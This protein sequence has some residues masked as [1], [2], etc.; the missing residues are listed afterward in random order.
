[1][2]A[3]LLTVIGVLTWVLAGIPT[4]LSHIEAHSLLGARAAI[5]ITAYV[6]WV[7]AFWFATAVQCERRTRIALLLAQSVLAIVCLALDRL[8]FLPVLLVMLAGELGTLPMPIGFSWIGIHTLIFAYLASRETSHPLQI[9][10]AYL[11]FQLFAFF[12]L[13]IAHAE[14]EARRELAEAH[15]ELK[16]ANG[17]LDLRTRSEERLRIA[18]DLHDLLGHHLTALSLNLE[19]AT[20]LTEGAARE[21]VEKSRAITKL[22]LSDVRDVV[23]RLRHDEPLDLTAA[24]EA[25]RNVVS[26]PAITIEA[27]AQLVVT[28]SAVAEVTLRTI[29]EIVTNSVRHASARHLRLQLTREGSTLTIT[30]HDDGVGTDDVRFGNGLRGMRERAEKIGGTV[31]V[32]SLRGHGFD[33]RIRLPLEVT[34]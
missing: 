34:H 27:P 16:V 12:A 13:R 29:Q 2:N 20:H 21:Q 25:L 18:R 28:D 9:A 31:E 26:S 33:V 14:A 17:L 5:W 11:A 10:L 4:V 15:A 3:R 22:L 7:I 8:G 1:M 30:G 6:L 32:S 23:S 19:V 24:L